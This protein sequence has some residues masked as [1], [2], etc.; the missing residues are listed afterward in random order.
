M[1]KSCVPSNGDATVLHHD[2]SSSTLLPLFSPSLTSCHLSSVSVWRLVCTAIIAHH[3]V[4]PFTGEQHDRRGYRHNTVVFIT[5]I[6]SYHQNHR[7]HH[8]KE[9]SCH[10]RPPLVLHWEICNGNESSKRGD[11]AGPPRYDTSGVILH[12]HQ[13]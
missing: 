6:A 9:Q 1:L 8:R 7:R 5:G 3:K 2:L 11:D 4:V 13:W 12:R 10:K